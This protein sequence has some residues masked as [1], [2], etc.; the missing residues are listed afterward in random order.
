[1]LLNHDTLNMDIILY[2]YVYVY[3]YVYVHMYICIYV[4][5]YRHIC[6][7]IELDDGKI[8]RK[9]LYL[10]VKT[11][12]S[13]KFSLK[14]TQWYIHIYMYTLSADDI[15]SDSINCCFGIHDGWCFSYLANLGCLGLP[16]SSQNSTFIWIMPRNFACPGSAEEDFLTF[17]KRKLCIY[18]WGYSYIWFI[19]LGIYNWGYKLYWGFVFWM[20]FIWGGLLDR[21]SKVL[22]LYLLM[23]PGLDRSD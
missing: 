15:V 22:L 21:K 19:F 2:I 12:V 11:M 6:I 5:M 23:V 10:M 7:F 16:I 3:V 1:M 8:Y 9:A 18:N 4:Y 14:P 13:C 17:S 20:S